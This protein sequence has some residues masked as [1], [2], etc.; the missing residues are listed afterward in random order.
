[1][2]VGLGLGRAAADTGTLRGRVM[3]RGSI[4]SLAGATVRVRSGESARELVADARGRFLVELPAGDAELYIAAPGH[5][6]LRA[7]TAVVAGK[8][9]QAEYLLR[10]LPA[11]RRPFETTVRGSDQHEGQ[12]TS[13][14]GE[15]LRTLPGGLGDPFR[16]IGL[17]AG[18]ATPVPLL[19]LFVVRGASPGMNGFFLDGMRVPQLFHLLVGGGV[20]H[21]RFVDA[22]DFYPGAYDASFGRYAGGI[23]DARTRPARS[24]GY[25]G[26][27]E[28]KLYDLAA[29]VEL[30]LPHEVRV[31]LSGHYGYPGPL[32]HAIDSRV[33][34]SYWDYQLRIDWRGLSLQALGSF[35]EVT[36]ADPSLAVPGST[37]VDNTFR[38]TFHRL[39]LRYQAHRGRLQFET[40]AVGGV[41][42][43]TIFQGNGVQKLSLNLRAQLTARWPT[44]RVHAG[45]DTELSRFTARN[46]S[47]DPMRARPDDLG[48]LAGSRDGVVASAFA[49]VT[50]EPRRGITATVSARADV[51]HA[52]SVTLVG[53]D[54]RL[55]LRAQLT[56]WLLLH[57][58]TGYY[59]QPPSFPVALPGIDTFALNLGLQHAVHFAGGEE[60]LLPAALSLQVTGFFQ[61]YGNANDI[62]IDFSPV[63]CTS[64]PPESLSGYAAQITRQIDGQSFGMEL[65]LRRKEGRFTGWVAYTLSRAERSF[66][67][68]LRP[69]DY[70]QTH[71]LNTVLQ[72]RLPWNLM[73]GARLFVS[74]GR[75]VTQLQPP[76]GSGTLRNNVRLP[77][78]VQLDLRLDREWLFRRFALDVFLEVVNA[79]YSQA[80]F[81]LAYPKEEGVTRY[82]QP[83]LNGFNWILPSIGVRGRF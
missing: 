2:C 32:V 49:V 82:D 61:K 59:Q 40:A 18:V 72:V 34:L 66:S 64:P 48:D 77:T 56:R 27:L 36:I 15:E 14:R 50:H 25:H 20:V 6:T 13:L 47:D 33:S 10:P 51:Y 42:E 4:V 73:A 7:H 74:T 44:L 5:E 78:T 37:T 9:T 81:G 8:T 69:A 55:Q 22:I 80:V 12:R 26:E 30:P 17:L 76:D 16:M 23:I 39:Q 70:D 52:G 31:T 35:D 75:P 19:P 41:D 58:G 57:V 63:A 71:V 68:G 28:L 83:M 54:P 65:M 21:P 3:A 46:F 38:Q 29:A 60:L 43:M 79:T 53:V 62:V 11:Y 67:C 24:D 1:L 45:V